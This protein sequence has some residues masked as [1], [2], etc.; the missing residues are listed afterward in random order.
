MIKK[1]IIAAVVIVLAITGYY[2]YKAYKFKKATKC[3]T[4][5]S[6]LKAEISSVNR[7][8][9]TVKAPPVR[10]LSFDALVDTR[11][12][13]I[14]D[15][16]WEYN[17]NI[18]SAI[19]KDMA[20]YGNAVV[21]PTCFDILGTI[22]NI[23]KSNGE[24]R[25]LPNGVYISDL[26]KSN[27]SV[28]E[29]LWLKLP[30]YRPPVN[31]IGKE[32]SP[33]LR[34]KFSPQDFLFTK[35]I[36]KNYPFVRDIAPAKTER[37]DGQKCT[38]YKII[39]DKDELKNQI[40]WDSMRKDGSSVMDLAAL[41]AYMPL[42]FG[43]NFTEGL[44][45][46]KYSD[47][48]INVWLNSDSLPQRLGIE[49]TISEEVGS[50]ICKCKLDLVSTPKYFEEKTIEQP[51][52]CTS[53]VST[54]FQ[55]FIGKIT[56]QFMGQGVKK[57]PVLTTETSQWEKELAELQRQSDAGDPR[58]MG[59]MSCLYRQGTFCAIDK[60]K[61]S[62]LANSSYEQKNP[63]G[64]YAMAKIYYQQNDPRALDL[65]KK[66]FPE[67][68]KKA[69][70]GDL[71]AQ[72]MIS[73][74]FHNGIGIDK[75]LKKSF[76]F[77]KLSAEGDNAFAQHMLAWHYNLGEG[78]SKDIPESEII[79]KQAA[80]QNLSIAQA[81]YGFFLMSIPTEE[82]INLGYKYLNKSCDQ[83]NYLGEYTLGYLYENG[84]GVVKDLNLASKY[85]SLS[86]EQ[87]YDLAKDALNKL[88]ILKNENFD[89]TNNTVQAY[90]SKGQISIGDVSELTIYVTDEIAN[91][92]E[93]FVNGLKI[94]FTGRSSSLQ[95]VNSHLLKRFVYSYIISSQDEGYYT[96]PSIQITI[97]N[98]KFSTESLSLHVG[99]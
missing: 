75:D 40:F 8:G 63:F 2:G 92:P 20:A 46:I 90:L 51:N 26:Q 24:V 95:M 83:K 55:S 38:L 68:Q 70:S 82:S 30:P 23:C 74:Y 69:K 73:D 58:A 27:D 57:E 22:L 29:H 72:L 52:N 42:L 98:K 66:A 94:K 7:E 77:K 67:L 64:T 10:I 65:Y 5:N 96:I 33:N 6:E 89:P 50:R 3:F 45:N 49:F 19:K 43:Y 12:K 39:I 61:A 79:E 34:F 18:N 60:A 54:Y 76:Q 36:K 99:N 48:V 93:I 35:D 31:R 21:M 56:A 62:E 81:Y 11:D 78:V 91:V 41:Q 80:D 88:E 97:N 87:G 1:V 44:K 9:Y 4:V 16:N 28:T 84:I 71:W 59:I 13:E 53:D 17:Q 25:V 86:A 85:Y 37:I 32:E 15:F 47:I 14:Y